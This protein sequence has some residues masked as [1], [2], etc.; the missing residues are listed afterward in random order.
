[1]TNY[2]LVYRGGGMPESE[3]EG[4]RVMAQWGQW[5]E[6]MGAAL[7]DGGNPVGASKTIGANGSVS[8]S[9]NPVSGYTIISAGDMDAAVEMAK[10]CPILQSGGSV[11]VGETFQIPG[12]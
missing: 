7:V 5:Y 10:G 4:Q 6:S 11:E 2:L 9:A 3:E 8:D 1:M 12:T